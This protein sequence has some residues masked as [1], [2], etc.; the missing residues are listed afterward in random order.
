MKAFLDSYEAFVEE[1]VLFMKKYMADPTNVSSMLKQ[2]TEIMEKYNAFAEVI[3]KLDSAEMSEADALYYLEVT[4]RCT[5]K[6]LKIY[7]DQ[8]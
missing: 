6:M 5:E 8:K 3:D 7:I 1:Y 4:T 2:Y